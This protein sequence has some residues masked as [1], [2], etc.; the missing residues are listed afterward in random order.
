MPPCDSASCL[1]HEALGMGRQHS[2]TTGKPT[3]HRWRGQCSDFDLA[4]QARGECGHVTRRYVESSDHIAPHIAHNG[5][6]M[7]LG[8]C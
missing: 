6:H 4:G 8:I 3:G 5:S 1:Q 2:L 7:Q